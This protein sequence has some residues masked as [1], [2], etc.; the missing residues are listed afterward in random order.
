MSP[1]DPKTYDWQHR[2]ARFQRFSALLGEDKATA[3]LRALAREME[4]HRERL[5][6]LMATGDDLLRYNAVLLAEIDVVLACIRGNLLRAPGFRAA[7]LKEES[8]LCLEEARAAQDEATRHSF[9]S[10]AFELAQAGE[11]IGRRS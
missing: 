4:Q 2:A 10:R 8:R 1:F 5:R 11:Q 7:D 3:P 9:A 6:D